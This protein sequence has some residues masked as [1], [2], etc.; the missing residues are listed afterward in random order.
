MKE[1]KYIYGF[2]KTKAMIICPLV[3]VLFMTASISGC[4]LAFKSTE[5]T[6]ITNQTSHESKTTE[7]V[8]ESTTETT[9]QESAATSTEADKSKEIENKFNKI[10]KNV[11]NI[12]KIIKFIDE[13]ISSANQDL[14]DTMVYTAMKL[15]EEY[16]FAFTD[17][18]SPQ[19]IQTAILDLSSSGEIDMKKLKNTD[20]QKIKDLITEAVNKKYKLMIVEGFVMPLVDYQ[21]YNTYRQYLSNEMNDYID[22]K[23]DESN[24]PSVLDAGIV[25]PIDDFIQRIL[26]SYNYLENYPD[27]PRA[28]EVKQFNHGRMQVYLGGIDNNPVFDSKNKI[29]PEKLIEFENNLSKYS[30]TKFADILNSYL[31]LLKQENY[32]KTQKIDEFL[33]NT[34]Y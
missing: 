34:D 30:G 32:L 20:N 14:A 31:E 10:D 9:A 8:P 23:L 13:N 28:N 29:L 4:N 22:I 27:S 15:C 33:N 19:E 17:K 2:K 26:K 12:E 1:I 3:I 16:K 18:F 6:P 24:R 11:D 21:A 5:T 7:S 25:I